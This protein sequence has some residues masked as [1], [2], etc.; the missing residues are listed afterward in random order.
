LNHL[1]FL[2]WD[3]SPLGA[4]VV[5]AMSRVMA[6][7]DAHASQEL[8]DHAEMMAFEAGMLAGGFERMTVLL[9]GEVCLA[10]GFQSGCEYAVECERRRNRDE[11]RIPLLALEGPHHHV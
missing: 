10:H 11:D 9:A 4:R 8:L 1:D 3:P 6:P 5:L 2:A 7:L